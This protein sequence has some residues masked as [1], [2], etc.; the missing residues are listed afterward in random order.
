MTRQVNWNKSIFNKHSKI[1]KVSRF[2]IERGEYLKINCRSYNYY[3]NFVHIS[4]SGW[5]S[6][7]RRCV[8]VAVQFSGRGFES[9]FWQYIL[10][11][12]FFYLFEIMPILF[13]KM[14]S[15][16]WGC[17]DLKLSVPLLISLIFYASFCFWSFCM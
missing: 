15:K 17:L 13:T 11:C 5:P 8:Q 9:H 4:M 12:R 14:P 2:I 10:T 1:L 6:G 3:F 7:L 16:M